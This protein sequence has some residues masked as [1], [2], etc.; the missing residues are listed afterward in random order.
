MT[1]QKEHVAVIPLEPRRCTLP[2]HRKIAEPKLRPI[3]SAHVREQVRTA[4][5]RG[6]RSNLA[7]HYGAHG[8]R[9]GCR[10]RDGR[11]E[12]YLRTLQVEVPSVIPRR[13]I[14]DIYGVLESGLMI[15]ASC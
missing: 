13:A 9:A 8:K 5:K 11:R 4:G 7:I 3:R 12:R 6:A 2:V 10:E 14:E 15:T 1:S